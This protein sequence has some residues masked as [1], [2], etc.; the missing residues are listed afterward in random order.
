MAPRLQNSDRR[1]RPVL[2]FV[3]KV[4]VLA[5]I[6]LAGGVSGWLYGVRFAVDSIL[7]QKRN[8]AEIPDRVLP[9]LED[10]LALTQDQV[11]DFNRIF[12]EYHAQMTRVEAK[13]ALEVHTLFYHMGKEI[14]PLLDEEQ[15]T[16]FR[17]IHR[18][19]C[20]VALGPIP[21]GVGEDGSTPEDPCEDL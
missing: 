5:V 20:T 19:I 1:R 16:E 14:L 8:M 21:A 11:P 2:R 12:R 7:E 4:F 9:R 15:A 13:R 10:D 17:D 18:R 3:V 6:F